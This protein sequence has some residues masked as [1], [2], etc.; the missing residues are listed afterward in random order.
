MVVWYYS[1]LVVQRLRVEGFR[2]YS[3][4]SLGLV[5]WV[6]YGEFSGFNLRPRYGVPV[7][8]M[9]RDLVLT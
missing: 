9:F 7:G 4:E 6:S 3:M 1:V 2:V 8:L 5:P